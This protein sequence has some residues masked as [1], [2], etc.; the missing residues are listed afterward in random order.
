MEIVARL[1]DR[2][3][4][5]RDLSFLFRMAHANALTARTMLESLC[6][7]QHLGSE[8]A[9]RAAGYLLRQDTDR[10]DLQ[11]RLLDVVRSTKREELR[12]LALAVLHAARPEA[13]MDVAPDFVRSRQ[14]QNAVFSTL[15]RLEQK[16]RPVADLLSEPVY[17]R[18][19]LGWLD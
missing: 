10:L 5:E 2:P 19:Q 18:G 3:S 15:V 6:K 9:V 11:R 16:G 7:A 13:A 4:A 14:L 8:S 1:S 12:G 17:R